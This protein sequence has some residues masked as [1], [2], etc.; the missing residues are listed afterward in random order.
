MY[1]EDVMPFFLVED[2]LWVDFQVF[3]EL[4]EGDDE[5]LGVDAVA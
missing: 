4:L 2:A 5:G 1:P 3:G